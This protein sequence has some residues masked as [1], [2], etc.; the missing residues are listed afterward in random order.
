MLIRAETEAALS[1]HKNFPQYTET[2]LIS[3]SNLA[4]FLGIKSIYIKDES[5]RF[6][7]N[8][9]KVLGSSYAIAN[10]IAEQSGHKLAE[11]DF[12]M[13]LSPEI[14]EKTGDITFYTATDGNHGRG[15]AW[16]ANI[17]KQ[18]SIVLMPKGSSPNRLNIIQNEGAEA[19][20]TELN[21][22]DTVR[23]AVK[24][25]SED[26]NGVVIQDTA[27]AGYEEIPGRIMQ[28][29]STL[30]C[31]AHAQLKCAG[32]ERPTHVFIQ[33]GV[34]SFAG[35]VIGIFKN[36]FPDNP[37]ITVVIEASAADN[38]YNS[39]VLGELV[40]K[41]GDLL[42]IMAGL[43]C[44]E[45]NIISWEILKNHADFFVSAPD[46]VAAKG[47]RLLSAPFTGDERVISGESGAVSSGL[48]YALLKDNEY[49][50]FADALG[51]NS[52]SVVL[53]FSTEGDTD[54]D[55]YR[56]IVWDGKY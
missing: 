39:C 51:L 38:L 40:V 3:L 4:A 50:D 20:I 14:K 23:L 24:K 35:T 17:L 26:P 44:G 7:L 8:A 15:V 22:D 52:D 16:A 5:F 12:R 2:P 41:K 32:I 34:G 36:Q 25:A 6:G 47:M 37:P 29:Y 46:R 43:S 42:T 1:F 11:L 45:G 27:W 31:E 18:K 56:S 21:Y 30:V 55:M 48:L 49:R 53:L 13:P 19:Y 9:F 33:A 28:G 54:P 10:Y